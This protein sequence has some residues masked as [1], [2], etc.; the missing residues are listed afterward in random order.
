MNRAF[1][2][3]FVAL[4][5]LYVVLKLL[6]CEAAV[7]GY[8]FQIGSNVSQQFDHLRILREKLWS[9]LTFVTIFLIIFHVAL[10]CVV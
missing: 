9:I 8:F 6:M 3:W 10:G 4:F 2:A 7:L 1:S 5:C